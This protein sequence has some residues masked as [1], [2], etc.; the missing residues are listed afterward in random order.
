MQRKHSGIVRRLMI[1]S[2]PEYNF[3]QNSN[4]VFVRF[5]YGGELNGLRL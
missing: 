5:I 3:D 2:A 4:V 1:G